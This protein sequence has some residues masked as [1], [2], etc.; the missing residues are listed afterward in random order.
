MH[1]HN[2]DLI[3]A[4]AEGLLA[5]DLIAAAEAE[6]AACAECTAELA[7]QRFAIDAL[8]SLRVPSMTA[9]ESAG[10]RQGVATALGLAEAPAP[11]RLRRSRRSP[12]PAIAFAAGLAAVLAIVP[13]LGL[14]NLGGDDA[15]TS[16]NTVVAGVFD[17]EETDA[18]S[19]E[20]AFADDVATS[21]AATTEMAPTAP[22]AGAESPMAATEPT[23]ALATTTTLAVDLGQQE[24]S[25]RTAVQGEDAI[26]DLFEAGPVSTDG[27]TSSN[28]P[29][30]RTNLACSGE[31]E[32]AF[33]NAYLY[34][35]VPASLDDGSSV[36]L[37]AAADWSALI[38]FDL[39]D[40]T[41][42]LSLP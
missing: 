22:V 21:A 2:H 28:E 19:D 18:L 16:A 24:Q 36:I 6:L 27:S 14:I 32:Q 3:A 38:A 37:Y 20:L 34:V 17:A 42:A 31:A 26:R 41:R 4:L 1:S 25:A 39:G 12:W 5:A 29:A 30:E 7:S 9:S 40:C 33:G 10:V 8:S 15:D 11:Q 35:S 13:A 23:E